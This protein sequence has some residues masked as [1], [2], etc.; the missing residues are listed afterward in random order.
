VL[1]AFVDDDSA[2]LSATM[3]ALDSR[4]K[5]IERWAGMLEK[6]APR[7]PGTAPQQDVAPIDPVLDDAEN[8][9]SQPL[10]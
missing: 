2:D 4:L 6:L 7:R 8:A 9:N 3:K 5:G 10:L 1:R